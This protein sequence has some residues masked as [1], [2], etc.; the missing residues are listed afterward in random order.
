MHIG[1]N[2]REQGL[3]GLLTAIPPDMD[4]AERYLQENHLGCGEVTRTAL[5]Y[6]ACCYCEAG[7]FAH[8]QKIPRPETTVPGLHSTY[9][10]DVLRLLLRYGLDPNGVYAGCNIMDS[11]RFVDNELLAAD[12]LALLLEHGGK[13]D[14][15]IPGEEETL[16]QTM[17][18]DVFFGAVE[19]YDRQQYVAIVH[20]WMVLLGYGAR[21]GAKKIQVFREYDSA[22]VFDLRKLKNHRNYYFGILHTERGSAISIYDKKTLWE[23]ARVG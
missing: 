8:E 4:G 6:A 22:E 15:R 13:T 10:L 3:L 7:D 1:L 2:A 20:C 12:A 23:L 11:L 19:Q 5:E 17:N 18:F 9:I 16:F 14:M 21:S